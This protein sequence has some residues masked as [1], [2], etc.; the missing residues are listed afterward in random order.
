MMYNLT[1]QSNEMIVY[2]ENKIFLKNK[3]S[4]TYIYAYYIITDENNNLLVKYSV[5]AFFFLI[6][7]KIISS[8]YGDKLKLI[9]KSYGNYILKFENDIYRTKFALFPHGKKCCKIYKNN[10]QIGYVDKRF[11][12]YPPHIYDINFENIDEKDQLFALI[13]LMISLSLVE[14]I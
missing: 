7:F 4:N 6:K 12:Q 10:K 14:D 1:I 3:G 9:K 13:D 11:W 5:F 8:K 2:K